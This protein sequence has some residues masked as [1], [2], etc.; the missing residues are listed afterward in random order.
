MISLVRGQN[1]IFSKSEQRIFAIFSF[2]VSYHRGSSLVAQR[3]YSYDAIG[4]PTTRN[5]ARQ[6]AVVNDIFAHNTRSELSSARVNGVSYGYAYDNIGNREFA[7]EG[8]KTSVYSA[9][10]LNQYTRIVEDDES[11]FLPEFD[12][13]GN[14]T[15]VQT[16]TGSWAVSYNNENRPTDFTAQDAQGNF[17][18]VQCSYD[19]MGRRSYKKVISG[20][21]VVLYQ[22]Y[23]YRGYLQI[24]CVDLTR[25]HHPCMWLITWDPT[26]PVATRPLAI[27]KDGTWRT[28]GLDLTKNVCEVFGSNGYINTAYTYTPFGEVT[29]SG[30]VTQPIQWSS[31][32]HDPELGMVYYNYRHY[33]TRDGR[34]IGR[35]MIESSTPHIYCY[36][37]TLLLFDVLGLYPQDFTIRKKESYQKRRYIKGK[38]NFIKANGVSVLVILDSAYADVNLITISKFDKTIRAKHRYD[39]LTQLKGVIKPNECISHLM[40]AGHGHSDYHTGDIKSAN[41]PIE[42]FFMQNER[43]TRFMGHHLKYNYLCKEAKIIFLACYVGSNMEL[44]LTFS[45]ATQAP[46]LV[47]ESEITTSESSVEYDDGKITFFDSSFGFHPSYKTW[48]ENFT[49]G[50]GEWIS[51]HPDGTIDTSPF[52]KSQYVNHDGIKKLHTSALWN[53]K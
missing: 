17:I 51:L 26:Q 29:A 46:V 2:F 15:R 45:N 43:E 12:A 20:G 38:E 10:A 5:T 39:V 4:R 1:S 30:S 3:E 32:F 31:E 35:D 33:N 14:Q 11:L 37:S 25:S 8:E 52:K 49:W 50:E 42:S 9:N 19:Y 6:G 40:I 16:S 21:E 36:N 23:I 24:A 34:W 7:V 22:R 28:Y 41:Y 13:D 48:N 27:Q 18:T 44:A 47:N 53:F